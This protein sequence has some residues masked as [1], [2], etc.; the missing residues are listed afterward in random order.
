MAGSWKQEG[1][2]GELTNDTVFVRN[3]DTGQRG[4]VCTTY[5]NDQQLRD[6]QVGEQIAKGNIQNLTP[7]NR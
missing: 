6:Q 5:T 3:T 2:R 1:V 4:S 7:P